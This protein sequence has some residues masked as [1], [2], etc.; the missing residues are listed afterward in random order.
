MNNVNRRKTDGNVGYNNDENVEMVN[1]EQGFQDFENNNVIRRH[2]DY[3]QI[4]SQTLININPDQ[5]MGLDLNNFLN[6]VEADQTIHGVSQ[7]NDLPIIA[8]VKI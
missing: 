2:S 8:E 7:T 3:S 4:N 5:P 1:N 6:N